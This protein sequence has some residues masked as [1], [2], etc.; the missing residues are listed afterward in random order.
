MRRGASVSQLLADEFGAAGG[1]DHAG[2]VD[3]GHGTDPQALERAKV[4]QV[5]RMRVSAARMGAHNPR[6]M[7][8]ATRLRPPGRAALPCSRGRR[9]PSGRR[10]R[11][12]RAAK[13]A[14]DVAALEATVDHMAEA[15]ADADRL[16]GHRCNSGAQLVP[17]LVP[18]L[19]CGQRA[20][21][22]ARNDRADRV[23]IVEHDIGVLSLRS[24]SI[25]ARE[26]RVIRIEEA[27]RDAR[28]SLPHRALRPAVERLAVEGGGRAQ[29]RRR[30]AR[31]RARLP[32][33]SRFTS[34][35][36]REIAVRIDRSRRDQRRS[37]RA[38]RSTSRRP[39][40]RARA[41]RGAFSDLGRDVRARMRQAHHEG[42]IA[43]DDLR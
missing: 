43:A 28:R 26:R 38:A 4:R 11:L 3:A 23:A 10:G 16:D 2:V 24:R 19:K 21:E 1:A 35:T 6:R 13:A 42:R 9:A 15:A 31:D 41:R 34:I 17:P 30:L 8:S 37:R 27:A 40:A 5:W 39:C 29:L 14:R 20:L 12:L 36:V 22:Q 33:G 25:S 18:M 32:D 7:A